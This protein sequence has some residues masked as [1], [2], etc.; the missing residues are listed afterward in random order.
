MMSLNRR[1][2]VS[3]LIKVSREKICV[4]VS[5]QNKATY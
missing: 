1:K 5:D 2:K 4:L 3:R